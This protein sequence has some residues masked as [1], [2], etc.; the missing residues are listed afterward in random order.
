MNTIQYIYK[1][2]N[3]PN[4]PREINNSSQGPCKSVV[5]T[6]VR[7]RANPCQDSCKSVVRTRANHYTKKE[8]FH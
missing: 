5:R 8:V 7:T 1:L 2:Y 4:I 3:I 6:R